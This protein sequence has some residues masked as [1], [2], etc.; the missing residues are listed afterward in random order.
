MSTKLETF[1]AYGCITEDGYANTLF[2]AQ[3]YLGLK[4]KRN[5]NDI[6]VCRFIL[7]SHEDMRKFTRWWISNLNYGAKAFELETIFL[8]TK[9]KLVVRMA[10][11]LSVTLLSGTLTYW[12]VPLKLEVLYTEVI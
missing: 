12:E 6:I 9:G 1:P 8:G 5:K 10:N 3:P 7:K 2:K 11:D 4:Y